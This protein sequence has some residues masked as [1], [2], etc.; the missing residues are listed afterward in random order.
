MSIHNITSVIKAG[1]MICTNVE[2]GYLLHSHS[3]IKAKNDIRFTAL[4]WRT[5]VKRLNTK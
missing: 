4:C 1:M 5:D 3:E 2:F